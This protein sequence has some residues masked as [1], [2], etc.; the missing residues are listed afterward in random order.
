M[1]KRYEDVFRVRMGP[2]PPAKISPMVIKMR[3]DARPV[4][5]MQRRYSQPQVAF[6]TEKVKKLVKVG[7]LV[8]N[9][10]AK[11]V[12]PIVVAPKPRSSEGFRFTVDL[13]DPN[14]QTIPM[15]SAMPNPEAMLH[16]T[17]GSSCYAKI[18]MCHAYWQLP[19]D[20]ESQEYS[21]DPARCTDTHSHVARRYRRGQKPP[22]V[23]I[24]GLLRTTRE[25][26]T[27]D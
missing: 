4:R 1:M 18:D 26:T 15:A 12:S 23:N 2:D 13:R 9:P 22:G 11:W 20:K 21:T 3:A 5:A 16:T 14:A 19:F 6:I 8:Y 10:N 25:S 7:A 17:E 24:G 27:V